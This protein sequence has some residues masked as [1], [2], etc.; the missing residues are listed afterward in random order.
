MPLASDAG[1]EAIC[2]DCLLHPRR[3]DRAVVP[4]RYGY[5]VD[6]LVRGFKYRGALA[7]G[8]VLATLL[9]QHL[10]V[11]ADAR[12]ELLIPVPLHLDRHRERGF[13]QSIELAR[14]VGSLLDLRVDENGCRRIRATED[15]AQLSARARRKN[16]RGAFEV[17]RT[18]GVDHV[19]IVDDV[20]TTGSTV[21]EI[22]RLLRRAG[23][24]T[25]EVWAVA[26]ATPLNANAQPSKT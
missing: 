24:K 26:R 22:A 13:N 5:P 16:V 7:Y 18:P 3:F 10:A 9:A 6:H 4:F 21:T 17:A 25:I 14:R 12:P 1:G 11:A 19:A 20:L 2:G 15:Q 23:V 8:R